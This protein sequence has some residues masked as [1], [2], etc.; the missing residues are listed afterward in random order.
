MRLRA[1]R[2]RVN[3]QTA[4]EYWTGRE[5]VAVAAGCRRADD[6][7]GEFIGPLLSAGGSPGSHPR[8]ARSIERRSMT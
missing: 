6:P 3:D 5:A 1:S 7:K 8:G 2:A 4:G